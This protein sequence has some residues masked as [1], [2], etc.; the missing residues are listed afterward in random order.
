MIPEHI[1]SVNTWGG[2]PDRNYYVF[3]ILSIMFGFLGIDHFYLRSF[4]TGVKKLIVNIFGLGIWYFWDILQIVSDGKAIRE[5]GLSS[6][7]DWIKGIGRGTFTEPT[8]L[9]KVQMGGAMPQ[10]QPT[11]DTA[12]IA[13][14]AKTGNTGN[15]GSTGN[16]GPV[17]A[18]KKSYLIY[19]F[20]AICFGWLGL[21]KLYMGHLAQGLFKLI[22]CFNIFLFLFGWMW[23]LWDSFHAFFLTN[24]ILEE[25]IVV[26]LPYSMLFE[27]IS[28]EDF[29]V[30]EQ[31]G[32]EESSFSVYAFLDWIAKEFMFP[33]VPNFG[34]MKGLYKDIAAPLITVPVVKA[35]QAVPNPAE[36][37]AAMHS[38]PAAQVPSLPLSL[39]E[40]TVPKLQGQ[41]PSLAQPLQ[42]MT[43]PAQPLQ[44]M[45]VPKVPEK[46]SAMKGGSRLLI[47]ESS[48]EISGPGPVV[49]GALTAIV[50]AGGLKGFYDFIAAQYG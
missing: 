5:E 39:Q 1:S 29:K 41:V 7:L 10:S 43:V 12:K 9:K 11:T 17:F 38:L 21:D 22:S 36:L 15:T 18:A 33:S 45:T 3:I 23:V 47:T 20:L 30:R 28:T 25:G 32:G 19:A 4:D 50:L 48:P 44:D 35:L 27:T 40:L 24:T 8:L 37:E 14:T 2:H 34:W 46:L 6:P 13:E 31:I 16:T 49:A 26:P 42:D